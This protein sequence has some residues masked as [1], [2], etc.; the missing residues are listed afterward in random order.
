MARLKEIVIDAMHPAALARFWAQAIDGYAVRAYDVAEIERLAA[1]G[2]TPETDTNVAVDGPGP[3]LFVQ[4]LHSPARERS[5]LH[6]DLACESRTAESRRLVA[7]G[8]RV[9][10]VHA[11]HTVM[12]DPEGNAFCLQGPP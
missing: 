12:L 7:L 6:L 5:R 2:L 8:A 4:Q 10:D 9:R 3:T 1:R 11:S